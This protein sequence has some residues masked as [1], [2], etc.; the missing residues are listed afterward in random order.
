MIIITYL[1]THCNIQLT[2]SFSFNGGVQSLIEYTTS[3]Q[4]Y[5]TKQTFQKSMT[6]TVM[7]YSS[8]RRVTWLC[9]IFWRH[10]EMRKNN[11]AHST[12]TLV[13]SDELTVSTKHFWGKKQLRCKIQPYE[14]S[15]PW[16]SN[17]DIEKDCLGWHRRRLPRL[18]PGVRGEH[19][20]HQPAITVFTSACPVYLVD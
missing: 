14:L 11:H 15:L 12:A 18:N 9:V 20:A 7:S 13:H 19:L 6:H 3:L 8:V 17:F 4:K 10:Y 5:S 1:L 2:K 16:K